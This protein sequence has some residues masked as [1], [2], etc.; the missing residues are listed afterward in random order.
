LPHFVVDCSESV[1]DLVPG[2]QIISEVHSLANSTGLFGEGDIKVRINPY[3]LYSCGNQ[4]EDFIQ[5]FS[6]ITEGRTDE[7]KEN[8][9][10]VILSKLVEMFPN[11]EHIAM[12]VIN[13]EKVSYCSRS[14]L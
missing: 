5:V 13:L 9:S 4:R 12:N 11:V 14:T 1:L 2:E 8:L 10:R 3:Q 6:S 7:Q